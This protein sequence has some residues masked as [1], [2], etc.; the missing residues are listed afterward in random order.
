[1]GREKRLNDPHD[2]VEQPPRPW[3]DENQEARRKVIHPQAHHNYRVV[4]KLDA[5]EPDD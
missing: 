1:M 5:G 2:R 3:L 4:L